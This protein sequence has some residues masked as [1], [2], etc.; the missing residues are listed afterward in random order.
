MERHQA[1]DWFSKFTGGVTSA[2]DVDEVKE[3]FSKNRRITICKSPTCW[4]FHVR[5]L[6][7][8]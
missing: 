1:F 5:Q 6:R 3:L 7:A 2:Q 4:E 8:F